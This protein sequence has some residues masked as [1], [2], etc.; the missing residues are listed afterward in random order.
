MKIYFDNCSLQLPLDDA[1]QPRIKIEAEAISQILLACRVGDLTMVS[2]EVLELEAA[3]MSDDKRR[4]LT[5]NILLV[6]QEKVEVDESITIRAEEL[7]ERGFKQFDALHLASAEAAA[8]DYFC[9][10]DDRLLKKAKAQTDLKT[11]TVSPL[12]L[13]QELFL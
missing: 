12:E 5:F 7:V 8:S 10:C 3:E 1:N 2:S 9:T 6:A 13:A 11:K 4:T